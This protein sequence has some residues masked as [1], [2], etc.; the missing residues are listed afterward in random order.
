MTDIPSDVQTYL[1][2]VERKDALQKELRELSATMKTLD[3]S[4]EHWLLNRASKGYSHK[5]NSQTSGGPGELVLTV[6]KKRK[7]VTKQQVRNVVSEILAELQVQDVEGHVARAMDRIQT[8]GN[9]M[10]SIKRKYHQV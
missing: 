9:P 6:R 3:Q 2:C 10:P 5:L 7:S 4:V 1:Q 8:Q